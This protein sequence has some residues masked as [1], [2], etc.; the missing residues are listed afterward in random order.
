MPVMGLCK[1][2]AKVG[3]HLYKLSGHLIEALAFVLR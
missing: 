2:Y 3:Y 1:L